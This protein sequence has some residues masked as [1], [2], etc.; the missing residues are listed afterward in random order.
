MEKFRQVQKQKYAIEV[1]KITKRKSNSFDIKKVKSDFQMENENISKQGTSYESSLAIEEELYQCVDLLLN[2]PPKYFIKEMQ[3]ENESVAVPK[4]EDAAIHQHELE[5]Y[6]REEVYDNAPVATEEELP[7]EDPE[8]SSLP[9]TILISKQAADFLKQKKT[10]K[11]V[12]KH[13]RKKLLQLGQGY[14]THALCHKCIQPEDK[15]FETYLYKES[16][17][18]WQESIQYSDMYSNENEEVYTDV[19]RVLW[20]TTTHTTHQLTDILQKIKASLSKSRLSQCTKTL[21]LKNNPSNTGDLKLP[22]T[23][24]KTS[25]ERQCTEAIPTHV[26]VLH[27][28]PNVFGGEFSVMQ[29]HPFSEFLDAYLSSDSS[30]FDTPICMSSEEHNIICLPYGKEPVILCG[31]SGTGKTTTCIYRMWNEFKTFCERYCPSTT[32]VDCLQDNPT[33]QQVFVTKSPVLCSQVKKQF[34]KL[35]NGSEQLKKRWINCDVKSFK[36]LVQFD[37]KHFPLFLTSRQFLFLLDNTLPGKPFFDRDDQAELIIDIQNWD[38]NHNMDP[39]ALFSDRGDEDEEEENKVRKEKW[40][41]VTADFFCNKIWPKMKTQKNF[42]DPLLVWMEIQ[43]FI[44][45][46][47]AALQSSHGYIEDTEYQ[48]IGRKMAPN[49]S[50]DDRKKVYECFNEYKKIL[51]SFPKAYYNCVRLF[52]E[53]DV[54]H[55]IFKRF[56]DETK[57]VDH[58]YIDEVQ[59]FTQAELSLL[60]RCSKNPSGTFCTGDTAQSIMKGVFF[61]FS[62]LKSQFWVM[63]QQAP[64][65]V[66]RLKQLTQNFRAHSG[67]LN[68]AQSVVDI[69]QKY[70][71]TSFQNENLPHEVAMFEGPK[72]ILLS[73]CSADDLTS[74]L[75]GNVDD[76][77][78]HELGAHQAILVRT[79]ESKQ[80]L[81]ESLKHGIVLTVLEAKGLEFNDV[82]LYNFFSDSE[83]SF[84]DYYIL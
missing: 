39:E 45:G 1:P 80:K 56:R 76:S 18:I 44:K 51:H 29:F 74:I 58:F 50:D 19:I 9:W 61:R 26:H 15:L 81:P 4:E 47:M 67:I 82:L 71:Q 77:T 79:E 40:T 70:F 78:H 72:P 69:I 28:I 52:D 35:V 48:R 66:P 36:S 23:F 53:N 3:I 49:Y 62:D 20:I 65:H 22:R 24:V 59:D 8:F 25:G 10:S 5:N 32:D 83:V 2:K 63:A 54:I 68:L 38:Y 6:E 31:R 16:R 33:L 30:N 75:L 27:P 57:F 21:T 73:S 43:S 12:I 13:I 11:K 60:L 37:N 7:F 84:L 46:S 34:E 42:Q 17:I 64:V 55:N 41:E 14:R